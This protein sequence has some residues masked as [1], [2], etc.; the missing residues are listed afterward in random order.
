MP[1][2]ARQIKEQTYMLCSQR[3]ESEWMNPLEYRNGE[4][5]A[6]EAF[7]CIACSAEVFY[8]NAR[9]IVV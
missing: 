9:T 5:I 3:M 7:G 1:L 4:S 6:G 8:A 2:S